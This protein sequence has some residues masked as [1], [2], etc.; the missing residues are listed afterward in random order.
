VFS[1]ADVPGG[2][3]EQR[4]GAFA[5]GGNGGGDAARN[6]AIDTDIVSSARVGACKRVRRRRKT[7]SG[8]RI[9]VILF[10]PK[11]ADLDSL[12]KWNCSATLS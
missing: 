9:G 10:S 5:P 4:L 6:A 7:G 8:E 11:S 3:D 2:F 12:R 1:P